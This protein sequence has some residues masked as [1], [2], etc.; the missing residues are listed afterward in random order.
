MMTRAQKRLSF[1]TGQNLD[2]MKRLFIDE[3]QDSAMLV[4]RFLDRTIH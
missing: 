4:R 1:W 2:L 3:L